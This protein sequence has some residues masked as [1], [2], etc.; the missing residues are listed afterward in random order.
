M[1][2]SD[3]KMFPNDPLRQRWDPKGTQGY[4]KGTSGIIFFL[5]FIYFFINFDKFYGNYENPQRIYDFFSFFIHPDHE[6]PQKVLYCRANSKVRLFLPTA[7]FPQENHKNIIKISEFAPNLTK[8]H[9][10]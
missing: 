4:P 6:K 2:P 8:N 1:I 5:I 10:K 7:F 9:K 3:S